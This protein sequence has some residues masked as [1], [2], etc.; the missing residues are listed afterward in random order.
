MVAAL[1]HVM[2]N[3]ALFSDI[4]TLDLGLRIVFLAGLVALGAVVFMAVC[5]IGGALRD[6]R[7]LRD[8]AGLHRRQ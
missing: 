3:W 7:A 5:L 8:P 1:A 4:V 6:V 2:Q